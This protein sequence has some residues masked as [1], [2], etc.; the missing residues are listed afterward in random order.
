MVPPRQAGVVVCLEANGDPP[1]RSGA[2]IMT[3]DATKTG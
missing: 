3:Q 2:V 1:S